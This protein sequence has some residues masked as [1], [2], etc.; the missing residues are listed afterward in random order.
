MGGNNRGLTYGE[1]DFPAEQGFTG[2][3]GKDSVKGYQRGGRV[4]PNMHDKLQKEGEK[5][6]FAQGGQVKTTDTSGRFKAK[7]GKMASMDH[8]VQ[9]ARRG[10]N[11]RNQAQAEAGGTGRLKPGLKAGGAVKKGRAAPSR[12]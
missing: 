6:G 10:A 2:S 9:P 4:K 3:A 5:L 7:R 8:G 11:A 12:K 1:F